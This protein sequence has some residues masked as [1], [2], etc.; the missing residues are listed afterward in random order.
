MVNYTVI[1]GLESQETYPDPV[2]PYEFEGGEIAAMVIVNLLAVLDFL[3]I[4]YCFV[5]ARTFKP[6]KA[7]QLPLTLL[8]AVGAFFLG[9][10]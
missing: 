7:R 10:R 8:T 2:E 9:W 1:G 6:L 3:V 4:G 5:R